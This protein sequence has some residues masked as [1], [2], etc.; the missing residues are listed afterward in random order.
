MSR[1][2]ALFDTS[3]PA[4]EAQADARADGDAAAG[5]VVSHSAVRRWLASWGTGARTPRPR[6]GD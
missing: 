1:E 2:R 3:D 4:A 5:R 6:A